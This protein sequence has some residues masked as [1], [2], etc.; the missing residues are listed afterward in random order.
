M[1]GDRLC[2]RRLLRYA[3]HLHCVGALAWPL[4]LWSSSGGEAESLH[5]RARRTGN[6]RLELLGAAWLV[7][8]S[9]PQS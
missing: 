6:A 4:S 8:K 2:D 5:V 7:N 3:Q 9:G 1:V